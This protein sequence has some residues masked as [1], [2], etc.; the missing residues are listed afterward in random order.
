[1]ADNL[2]EIIPEE[3]VLEVIEEKVEDE[4]LEMIEVEDEDEMI[5]A[6]AEIVTAVAVDGNYC[7]T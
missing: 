2:E 7:K 1:M 4:T 5:E 3:A 6:V